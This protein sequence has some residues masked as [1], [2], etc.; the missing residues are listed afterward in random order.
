MIKNLIVDANAKFPIAN[1]NDYALIF[2]HP[3]KENN[4]KK[5]TLVLCKNKTIV[6][7]DVNLYIKITA[8]QFQILQ[9][10]NS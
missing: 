10:K 7:T 5:A 3:Q 4:N 2:L 1:N 9:W 8:Q 6:F